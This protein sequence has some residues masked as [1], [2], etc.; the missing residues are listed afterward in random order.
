MPLST[1]RH[2]AKHAITAADRLA[3]RRRLRALL[4]P[5]PHGVQGVYTVRSLYFDDPFDTAL[6]QKLDG[7]DR[8]EKFRLRLYDGDPATLHLEK[9]SRCGGLGRK[10]AAPL[11]PAQAR[12]LLGGDI[13][14]MAGS[15]QPLLAELYARMRC[16][17]LRPRTL[18]E[19]TRE[20]Y[21]YGPG[22]V[23]VTIDSGLRTGLRATDLLGPGCLTVPAPGAGIL[24]E[25][26]WGAF[27]PALVRDA[28]QLPGVRTG[29]F[30]KYAACRAYDTPLI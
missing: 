6:R 19:Y 25:V 20:A 17:R 2:E 30:S 24:L 5:D 21:V 12:A 29:T 23:R 27:L 13:A 8:R 7:V 16:D 22:E 26:K 4:P 18:V 10:D 11:T 28:V 3:L 1:Y 9:K 14:W 15:G